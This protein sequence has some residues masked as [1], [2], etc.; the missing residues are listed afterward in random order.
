VSKIKGN[1]SMSEQM[2]ET[3]KEFFTDLKTFSPNMPNLHSTWVNFDHD[4]KEVVILSVLDDL[5][6]D[7]EFRIYQDLYSTISPVKDGYYMNTRVTCLCGDEVA[8][9]VPENFDMVWSN[10]YDVSH[11][12][13]LG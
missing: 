12:P 4:K 13:A 10:G 3:L 6:F 11:K 5:D 9:V 2:R 1:E 7:S 8:E